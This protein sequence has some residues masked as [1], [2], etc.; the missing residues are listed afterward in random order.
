MLPPLR[1]PHFL[2]QPG[3]LLLRGGG[4]PRRRAKGVGV[5]QLD[6]LIELEAVAHQFVPFDTY[7]PVYPL[8]YLYPGCSE[9]N[10]PAPL[11]LIKSLESTMCCA[12][13]GRPYNPWIYRWIYRW[14]TYLSLRL[15]QAL[16]SGSQTRGVHY[17]LTGKYIMYTHAQTCSAAQYS[18]MYEYLVRSPWR[19]D[20]VICWF[21]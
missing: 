20:I 9:H 12:A 11:A 3:R 5:R 13:N 1:R 6:H 10:F 15:T 14:H 18:Y 7:L 21:D 4:C 8:Y 19:W 17:I 16:I 2:P